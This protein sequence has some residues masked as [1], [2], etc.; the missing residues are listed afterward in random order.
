MAKKKRRD[1]EAERRIVAFREQQRRLVKRRNVMGLLGIV[2]LVAV[3]S[4]GSGT[5][6]EILCQI[7]RDAWL[8]AWAAL[9]GSFLGMSIRIFRERR[10]FARAGGPPR[11]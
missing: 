9:V 11:A 6:L 1:R 2:P 7:P 5:P 10:A 8:I 3:L 4:C